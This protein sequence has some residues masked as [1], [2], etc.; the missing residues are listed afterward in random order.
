MRFNRT[1]TNTEPPPPEPDAIALLGLSDRG[2]LALRLAE[3]MLRGLAH[4]GYHAYHDRADVLT[5]A[6]EILDQIDKADTATHPLA[7]ADEIMAGRGPIVEQAIEME[8]I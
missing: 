7:E 5:V 1:D 4:I 8:T 3:R 2:E 6:H